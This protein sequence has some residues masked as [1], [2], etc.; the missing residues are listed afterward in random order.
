[1]QEVA[2]LC[3]RFGAVA[4]VP[5]LPELIQGCY[6]TRMMTLNHDNPHG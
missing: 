3:R 6:L 4:L 2:H 5:K 1:M